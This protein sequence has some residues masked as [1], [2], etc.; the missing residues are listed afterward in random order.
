MWFDQHIIGANCTY[1]RPTRATN[2]QTKHY[3]N[4]FAGY[5]LMHMSYHPIVFYTTMRDWHVLTHFNVAYNAKRMFSA[6][7][8]P[9]VRTTP[10]QLGHTL[11]HGANIIQSLD[12]Y[13]THVLHLLTDCLDTHLVVF[14]WDNFTHP[15][16]SN[17]PLTQTK[18]AFS[19]DY[20][21]FSAFILHPPPVEASL[22]LPLPSYDE[23]SSIGVNLPYGFH[24]GAV[25]SL[26]K[27]L[28]RIWVA[29]SGF[30][31]VDEDDATSQ[32]RHPQLDFWSHFAELTEFDLPLIEV[33]VVPFSSKACPVS[34]STIWLPLAISRVASGQTP[35]RVMGLEFLVPLLQAIHSKGHYLLTVSDQAIW[36]PL[37]QVMH[38]MSPS[39]FSLR[40]IVAVCDLFHC[41]AKIHEAALRYLTPLLGSWW[42]SWHGP[43][44]N[45]CYFG[46]LSQRRWLISVWAIAWSNLRE[47]VSLSRDSCLETH[48]G[49]YIFSLLEFVIPLVFFT[50]HCLTKGDGVT[51]LKLLSMS[52]PLLQ[53]TRNTNYSL[54]VSYNVLTL[55]A[56]PGL[57]HLFT[58]FAGLFSAERGEV[59]F[60]FLSHQL[61][62]KDQKASDVQVHRVLALLPEYW[63]ARRTWAEFIEVP[64][65]GS[66]TRDKVHAQSEAVVAT[67]NFLHELIMKLGAHKRIV[68]KDPVVVPKVSKRAPS[69]P[70]LVTST[71]AQGELR[72]TTFPS[73]GG[74]LQLS[75]LVK[76]ATQWTRGFK[77]QQLSS[78]SMD[79]VP[80]L[81]EY[82]TKHNVDN[83]GGFLPSNGEEDAILNIMSEM[84]SGQLSWMAYLKNECTRL[85]TIVPKYEK[86]FQK[87]NTNLSTASVVVTQPSY[88]AFPS[89]EYTTELTS[90]TDS[91]SDYVDSE[92]EASSSSQGNEEAVSPSRKRQKTPTAGVDSPVFTP[93]G[94]TPFKNE[95]NS[96]TNFSPTS[97]PDMGPC[98]LFATAQPHIFDNFND[99]F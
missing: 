25:A 28:C 88:E 67:K 12:A 24:E 57:L 97:L 98:R 78:A 43:N 69:E 95:T 77:E 58:K 10:P 82:L 56:Y 35:G 4:M 93:Q 50:S 72:Q 84:F 66:L 37:V 46:K 33:P 36:K 42:G 15:H 48:Y 11:L 53:Y 45:M 73:S 91:S 14:W 5:L 40:G 13:T 59:A 26:W 55:K 27:Y 85:S 21:I 19:G 87:L 89:S 64:P 70:Q 22:N 71:T 20:T 9:G 49:A 1:A 34:P 41:V 68:C 52:I 18:K 60:K 96:T 90:A 17:L 8:V 65:R 32:I 7:S 6:L 16:Y 75:L 30:L 31:Q 39:A 81:P 83:L 92:V 86:C 76:V 80:Q 63:K 3:R 54:A 74:V 79:K 62:Y 47:E 2:A 51:L 29:L 23:A 94:L 99:M 44:T 61:R 38:T